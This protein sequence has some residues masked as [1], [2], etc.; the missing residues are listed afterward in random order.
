MSVD[1]KEKAIS[2]LK[3]NLLVP[4]DSAAETILF[5]VPTG[6]TCIVTHIIVHTPS[7]SLSGVTSVA[8]GS[9]AG[10]RNDWDA[11]ARTLALI[12][13]VTLS[14]MLAATLPGDSADQVT[15][16]IAAAGTFGIKVTTG[17]AVTATIDVFG[18]LY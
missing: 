6:K 4:L 10:T 5:T 1:L 7:A 13:G 16:I 9:N 18:F 17:A 2:L 14:Q 3:S 11:S 12:T 15:T 8:F